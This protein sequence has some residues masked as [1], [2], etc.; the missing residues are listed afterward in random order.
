MDVAMAIPK[1]RS[2]GERRADDGD[3][4]REHEHARPRLR[5]GRGASAHLR[6]DEAVALDVV[7]GR[8]A[9]NTTKNTD[10]TQARSHAAV[11]TSPLNHYA[12]H[13]ILLLDVVLMLLPSGVSCDGRSF[14]DSPHQT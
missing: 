4:E 1:E 7:S 9:R 12:S 3:G 5:S 11:L 14:A 10:V 13:S 6:L 8:A 2:A